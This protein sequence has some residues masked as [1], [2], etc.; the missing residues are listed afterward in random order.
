MTIEAES[1]GVRAVR[2]RIG[3][4]IEFFTGEP[5]ETWA[6]TFGDGDT[7]TEEQP[8]HTY[9]EPGIYEVSVVSGENSATQ[10]ITIGSRQDFSSLPF[11]SLPGPAEKA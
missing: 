2:F 7:S 6:W 5:G 9:S 4:E 3:K 11:S 10:E 1:E 8:K